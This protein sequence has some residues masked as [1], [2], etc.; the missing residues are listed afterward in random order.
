MEFQ[1]NS[2]FRPGIWMNTNVK[3]EKKM[4]QM[5]TLRYIRR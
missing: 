5:K 3:K 1:T 2:P 4:Q